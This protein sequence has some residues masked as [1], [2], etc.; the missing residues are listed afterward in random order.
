M[1]L[2]ALLVFSFQMLLKALWLFFCSNN[3]K[4]TL[5]LQTGRDEVDKEGNEKVLLRVK[6]K[7]SSEN[8]FDR[9]MNFTVNE[10]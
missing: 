8:E 9:C 2:K 5:F 7:N 3:I 6:R 1:L 10:S 4:E